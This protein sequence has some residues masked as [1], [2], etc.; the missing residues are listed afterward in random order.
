M[1]SRKQLNRSQGEGLCSCIEKKESAE[2]CNAEGPAAL[3]LGTGLASAFAAGV[4]QVPLSPPPLQGCAL[5]SPS[6]LAAGLGVT[7]FPSMCCRLGVH[8]APRAADWFPHLRCEPVPLPGRLR[9]L[10][11]WWVHVTG[12]MSEPGPALRTWDAFRTKDALVP[13]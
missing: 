11:G 7:F 12:V 3:G 4:W 9:W 2:P 6:P 1:P 13:G 5:S 10:Q 8:A